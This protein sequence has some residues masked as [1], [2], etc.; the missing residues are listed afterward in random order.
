MRRRACGLGWMVACSVTLAS[1]AVAFAQEGDAAK[2]GE[3]QLP[4][5][6][7]DDPRPADAPR[8]E[9]VGALAAPAATEL[10][11]GAVGEARK[12]LV[13]IGF[14]HAKTYSR[15]FLKTT[16]RALPEVVP[17]PGIVKVRL[18]NTRS[19]LRNNLRF[20]DTSYFPSALWRITPRKA[21]DDVDVEIQMREAVAYRL[22]RKG[23]TIYV[24]FDPPTKK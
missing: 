13:F 9:V 17:G 18:K 15:V 5:Q 23:D 10:D 4:P 22:K 24:D 2:S 6:S 3:V 19:R 11:E 12:T 20:V 16:A 21:G 8:P 14:H 7:G 1:A